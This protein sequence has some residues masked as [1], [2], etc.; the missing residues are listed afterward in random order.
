MHIVPRPAAVLRAKYHKQSIENNLS[1]VW[2]FSAIALLVFGVHLLHHLRLGSKIFNYDM[3]AYT[4][5]YFINVLYAV[6]NLLVLPKAKN[7]PALSGVLVVFELAYPFFLGTVATLLAIV[8][9]QQGHG[10]VPYVM[11]MLVISIVLQ[12]QYVALLILLIT[13]WLCLTFGLQL[14][15]PMVQASPPILTG[16]TTIL[17]AAAVGRLTEQ[18]RVKQFEIMEELT[19]KNQLLEKL[20]I[21]DPLTKLYNRRHF[22]AKLHEETLRSQRYGHPLGLLLIDIDDFKSVNDSAGHVEGDQVLMQAAQLIT[23]EVREVDVVCRYGGDEFVVL[24]VEAPDRASLEIANRICSQVSQH[25]F[26]ALG[27]PV[28][29]SIGHTQYQGQS[30]DEF[31]QQ[32]DKMMYVAKTLGKSR[33]S[34]ANYVEHH[35]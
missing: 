3:L 9:S 2:Y 16:F 7:T 15:M 32:A 8:T 34:S 17:I 12:G 4:A 20:S 33:V 5:V 26:N 21:E 19:S 6:F 31:L 23:A 10:P 27:T 24:L 35:G 11:G 29:V 1:L 30:M 18:S 13:S 22:N 14:S 28:S 25:K